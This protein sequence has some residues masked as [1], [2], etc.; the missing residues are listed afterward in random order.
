MLKMIDKHIKPGALASNQM[1]TFRLLANLFYHEKGENF[2]LSYKD[3]ILKAVCNLNSLG[4][5]HNQVWE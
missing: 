5:K 2:C 3:D 4:N 1:L